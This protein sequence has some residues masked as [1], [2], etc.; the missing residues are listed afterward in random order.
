M[1]EERVLVTIDKELWEAND[2]WVSIAMDTL[3][4]RVAT[5]DDVLK[6]MEEYPESAKLALE[7]FRKSD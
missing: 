1:T 4:P 5:V 6:W 2:A 7:R 3:K